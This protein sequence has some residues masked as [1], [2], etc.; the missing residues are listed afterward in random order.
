MIKASLKS[1]ALGLSVDDSQDHLISCFKEGKKTEEGA[2]QLKNQT[3]LLQNDEI[4]ANP[5]QITDEDIADAAPLCNIIEDD[6]L[7]I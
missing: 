3:L 6:T 7:H 5:F 1:C 4:D 2:A